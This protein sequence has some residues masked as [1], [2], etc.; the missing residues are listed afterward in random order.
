MHSTLKTS[1]RLL[2]AILLGLSLTLP[3]RAQ[4]RAV[5]LASGL[6]LPV[7]ACSPQGDFARIFIVER[8]GKIRV[9]DHGN[10]LATPFLDLN[11]KV[12]V[13]MELGLLGLAFHPNYA[14]N[15]TFFVS[16]TRLSDGASVLERYKVS[17]NDPN[18]ADP[19]S[20]T[21]IAG[22]IAQLTGQHK[23][24]CLQFGADHKLYYALGDGGGA[25]DSGPGHPAVGNAQSGATLLGKIS[26]FDV[27][28][29]PPYIPAHNPFVLDAG[30]RDEVWAMGYRNPWRFS[31]D[32]LTGDMY[33][34]D[35]GNGAVEEIDFEPAGMGGRNYGWK[36]MEGSNCTGLPTC[37]CNAPAWKLPIEEFGHSFACAVIG[38]YVYRGCAIGAMQGTYFY[39]DYCTARVW[40][41]SYDGATQTK[42]PVIER[43]S[44]LAPGG[45][46]SINQISSFGEDAYGEL[47]ICDLDG[48]LY[49]MV[50]TNQVDCNANGV[51]D[52]CDLSFGTSL[53]VNAN[54]IP[55]ECDG[56]APLVY[57]TAK[58]NSLSCLPSMSFTGY[59]SATRGFGFQVRA[60]NV[61]NNKIGILLY[62]FNGRALIPFQGGKLCLRPPVKRAA[63]SNSGGSP[64]PAN[65]C[66]GVF[67]IDLNSFAV[68]ALGGRPSPVLRLPGV[69]V[70]A[71]WWGR[72][73][74]IPPPLGSQLSNGLSF[75]ICP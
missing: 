42:G 9:L 53:D 19:L 61:L 26:R 45:G 12:G 37:G 54:Q 60:S 56:D 24:G 2:G 30:V 63:S 44:Q 49:K 31:F 27:D 20:A 16:Y 71:Q 57:C 34:G 14:A 47:L 35:V 75:Q 15:G 59:P 36:C 29:P 4:I 48:E 43:T 72:D 5:R 18:V 68:G 11:A 55:D 66:S 69:M 73:S 28:L 8:T 6:N 51:E 52:S 41:F 1:L 67:S 13:G 22:P 7:Y 46:M 50:A 65:D 25:G 64:A 70:V 32:R 58:L 10:L 23:A 21:L 33:V 17:A 3:A 62:G 39:G 74:G 40:S 38:G